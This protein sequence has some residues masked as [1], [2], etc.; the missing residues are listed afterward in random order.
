[1]DSEGILSE[2]QDDSIK[3]KNQETSVDFSQKIKELQE[4]YAKE[5]SELENINIDDIED[6]EIQK[7]NKEIENLQKQIKDIN[8][9]KAFNE[10][11]EQFKI[12][13]NFQKDLENNFNNYEKVINKE[14][15]DLKNN[16]NN[17]TNKQ[18]EDIMSE[19]KEI[20]NGKVKSQKEINMQLNIENEHSH[21]NINKDSLNDSNDY[22]KE[23]I[24]KNNNNESPEDSDLIEPN[25]QNM[26]KENSNDN[27]YN[28]ITDNKD[29]LN[30]N[31]FYN[32]ESNNK[33]QDNSKNIIFNKNRI[34]KNNIKRTKKNNNSNNENQ[35]NEKKKEIINYEEQVVGLRT[36]K[37][38][39]NFGENNRNILINEDKKEYNL[40]NLNNY[41]LKNNINLNPVDNNQNNKKK[42]IDYGKKPKEEP[43]KFNYKNIEVND[44]NDKPKISNKENDSQ[45]QKLYQ[46]INSIFFYDYQQKYIKDQKINEDK[47]E[48]LKK[49][50]FNDKIKGRNILKNYYMNYIETIILPLFK[51]NK[52]IIQSK[53]ETIKYNISVILECLGIDKNY[54]NSFYYQNEP[55]MKKVSKAQS[56]DAMLKFRNEFKISKEDITDEALENRLKENNLDIYKT[57]GKIFG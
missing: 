9:D 15:N 49:E 51:K 31:N 22:E 57:F 17:Q 3:S 8:I 42:K 30:K 1:M 25:N 23:I 39:E 35:N 33:N 41:F 36:I 40:Y 45:T 6:P 26:N 19:I 52:N 28:N 4:I 16:I 29:N 7:Q 44:R 54:Y 53:L 48:E 14:I 56:I 18:F 32:K 55:S 11:E 47:K 20:I 24:N 13:G 34:S 21:K 43:F 2:V 50:I 10:C 12:F 5:L 27:N 38:D 37:N 46:S